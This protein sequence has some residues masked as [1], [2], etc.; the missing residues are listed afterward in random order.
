MIKKMVMTVFELQ[1]LEGKIKGVFSDHIVAMVTNCA[2]KLRATCSSMIGKV[3]DTL[4]FAST[5]KRWL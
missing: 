1:A 3:F 2:T 4:I 5:D